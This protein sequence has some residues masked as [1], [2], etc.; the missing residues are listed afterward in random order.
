MAKT[1][2]NKNDVI[3]EEDSLFLGSLRS[4]FDT[5]EE[6]NGE[7]ETLLN[8]AASIKDAY[9]NKKISAK[10]A[11]SMLSEVKLFDSNG[12]EWTIGATSNEWYRRTFGVQQWLKSPAPTSAKINTTHTLPA[13]VEGGFDALKAKYNI[14]TPV[15]ENV[16]NEEVLLPTAMLPVNKKFDGFENPDDFES[17]LEIPKDVKEE[18]VSPSP[19]VNAVS[20]SDVLGWEPVKRS[21]GPELEKP[22]EETVESLQAQWENETK[23]NTDFNYSSLLEDFE[24]GL[25]TK[26]V[27]NVKDENSE[28]LKTEEIESEDDNSDFP[29]SLFYRPEE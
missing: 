18:I 22:A 5:V 11:A 15:T 8:V 17:Y 6:V 7:W 26:P 9:L 28:S 29:D 4:Q 16:L 12:Y 1:R 14:E 21:D 24:S 27:K 2:Q 25:Q 19:R 13:W 3:L 20:E 10:E 23:E